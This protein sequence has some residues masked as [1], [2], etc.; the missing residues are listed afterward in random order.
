[1]SLDLGSGVALDDFAITESGGGTDVTT[2]AD[3][4]TCAIT[5]T[6]TAL[7]DAGCVMISPSGE[8]R[9]SGI[10]RTPAGDV[11]TCTIP[12]LAQDE[13]GTWAVEYVFARTTA[14]NKLRATYA[15]I[16]A[17]AAGLPS[18][19]TEADLQVAVTSTNEDVD[20]P[21]IV[22][23]TALPSNPEQGDIVTCTISA[24]DAGSGIFE[25]GCTF[26][27]LLS[28][29][30]LSTVGTSPIG[31]VIPIDAAIGQWTEVNRF[32]RDNVINATTVE[33]SAV[34]IVQ[35]DTDPCAS[36]IADFTAPVPPAW[37]ATQGLG[38]QA[39]ST[40]TWELS[41]IHI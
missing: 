25:T 17:G 5:F 14:T 29:D 13:A 20:P 22:G 1:M 30:T 4:V 23:F 19:T 12:F 15:E 33:G 28:G 3:S 8:R 31:L 10:V 11:W 26:V 38:A 24:T 37:L 41:L 35:Q 6:G 7:I 27:H 39:T 21:S 18:V 32:A 34:F 9:R 2:A 36:T 16:W 40:A